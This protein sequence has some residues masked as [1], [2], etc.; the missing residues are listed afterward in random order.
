VTQNEQLKE[1]SVRTFIENDEKYGK[2]IIYL[3]TLIR[4]VVKALADGAIPPFEHDECA[5][6]SNLKYAPSFVRGRGIIEPRNAYTVL[7]IAKVLKRTRMKS[8]KNGTIQPNEEMQAA[9]KLLTAIESGK[10]T[11]EEAQKYVVMVPD[12]KRFSA[13]RIIKDKEIA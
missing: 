2:D 12:R 11:L 10:C 4:S 8:R 9:F 5:T 6:K 13:D 1:V 3:M 7:D